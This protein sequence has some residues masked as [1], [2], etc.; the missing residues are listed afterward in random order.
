MRKCFVPQI[1]TSVRCTTR[2]ATTHAPTNRAASGARVGRASCW[3]QT[4][5]VATVGRRRRSVCLYLCLSVYTRTY[6]HMYLCTSVRMYVYVYL[7]VYLYVCTYV[8]LFVRMYVCMYVYFYVCMYV[9][10]I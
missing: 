7:Y 8:R 4:A 3:G 9:C 5:R 2:G 1:L 6:V 10:I